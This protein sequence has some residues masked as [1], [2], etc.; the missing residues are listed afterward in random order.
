MDTEIDMKVDMTGITIVED[1]VDATG[2]DQGH[3]LP[4]SYNLESSWACEGPLNYW[5]QQ[6]KIMKWIG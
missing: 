5:M 3:I 6:S 1:T 4:V 2:P